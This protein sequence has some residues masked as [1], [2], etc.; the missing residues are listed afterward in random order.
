MAVALARCPK[1][2]APRAHTACPKCGLLAERMEAFARERA[3]A[4]APPASVRAAW[5]QVCERWED[6]S[7]HDALFS[8]TTAHKVFAWTAARYREAGAPP[9][10]STAPYRETTESRPGAAAYLERVRK[11]AEATLLV[12]ATPR[13]EHRHPYMSSLLVLAVLALMVIVGLMLAMFMHG[14]NSASEPPTAPTQVR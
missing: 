8:L 5:D 7:A 13:G 10:A 1:C 4:P 9:P 6:A 14:R 12:S 3:D 2:G 11:A